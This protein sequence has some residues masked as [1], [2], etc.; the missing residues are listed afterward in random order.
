MSS[1][2][3]DSRQL[4]AFVTLSRTGSFTETARQLFLTQ[5]AI[6]HSI[7][8]LERDLGCELFHRL[9]KTIH[10]TAAGRTLFEMADL[11]LR[12]MADTRELLDR[13][14]DWGGGQL[15]L[16]AGPTVCQYILPSA[17]REF[18]ETFPRC[19]VV[20]E[21]EDTPEALEDLATNKADMAFVLEPRKGFEHAFHPLFSDELVFLVPPGHPWAE[22]G[23]AIHAEI[24]EQSF[25][26]YSRQSYTYRQ[27]LRYFREEGVELQSSFELKS[28][29]AIKEMVK[30]SMGIAI[31]APWVARDEILEGS[32]VAVP[33]GRRKIKRTWGVACLKR[34]K[35]SLAEHTF[36]GLCETVCRN[37]AA[38]HGGI[39]AHHT[40]EGV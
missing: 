17:L 39:I 20:L 22:K 25:I 38:Q 10:L 15:R 16:V 35:L 12:Q 36:L 4:L 21:A 3:L 14:S 1:T 18:K 9:G 23:R 11:V 30:I 2:P 13:E 32:L 31:L 33:L 7:K 29:E 8:A 5:S 28:I 24:S 34:R 6:S 26:L 37:L 27:M 40:S 19:Q